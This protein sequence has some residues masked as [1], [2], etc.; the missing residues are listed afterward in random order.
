LIGGQLVFNGEDAFEDLTFGE[1][2]SASMSYTVENA[3]GDT[4]TATIDLMFKGVA[5]TID[6]LNASLPTT[7]EYQILGGDLEGEIEDDGYTLVMNGTVDDRFDG[8]VFENAYC[9]SILDPVIYAQFAEDS[10]TSTGQISGS[11]DTSVFGADQISYANGES[12]ADNLDLI[13]WIINED[14]SNDASGQYNDWEVQ[15]AIWE[16]TD[17]FDTSKLDAVDDNYGQDADVDAILDLA[18]ANGEGFVA[19]EG[20]IATMIVDPG[21]S[22]ADH[23]QPFIVAYD[24]DANNCDCPS[25]DNNTNG[26]LISAGTNVASGTSDGATVGAAGASGV[27][28]GDG[29]TGSDGGGSEAASILGLALLGLGAFAGSA[30]LAAA[31]VASFLLLSGKDSDDSSDDADD[32]IADLDAVSLEDIIPMTEMLSE[33]AAFEDA[34]DGEVSMLDF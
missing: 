5:E 33:D 12:A 24:F 20:D 6:E 25:E 28:T 18:I 26:G 15:R 22:N 29:E 23:S 34:E 10:P 19:G 27:A 32:N 1:T 3:D 30:V 7:G 16:L 14:F 11:D 17:G 9:L 4:S 2:G 8:Q 13:N 21:D 31:G